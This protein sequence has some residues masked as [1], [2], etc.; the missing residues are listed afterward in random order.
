MNDPYR[1]TARFY[2]TLVEPPN[3]VLRRIGLQM[4]PPWEG[5]RVLEVGCGTGANLSLYE[6]AGCDVFGIDLSPA[7]LEVASRKLSERADLR[8]ADAAEMPYA[9][10]SFDLVTSFL[11]LHEM[12]AATRAAV[13][14]EMVR[15]VNQRGRLLLIDYRSGPIRFPKGWLLKTL[16][17]SIELAAGREHFRNYRDFLARQGLAGLISSHG[18][19]VETEKVVSA[20]N[21]HAYVARK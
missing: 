7:M 3:V 12:P 19:S 16:I 21:M 20:G 9:D 18:L 10:D 17:V 13:M 14:D 1:R 2:D 6:N 5:M 11:T 8:L 4:C 15:V